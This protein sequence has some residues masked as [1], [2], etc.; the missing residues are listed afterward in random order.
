MAYDT[1][2][3]ILEQMRKEIEERLCSG[4]FDHQSPQLHGWRAERQH[5]LHKR[6]IRARSKDVVADLPTAVAGTNVTS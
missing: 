2:F 3:A 4:T 6:P 1:Q 5:A